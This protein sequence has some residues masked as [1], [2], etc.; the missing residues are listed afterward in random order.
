MFLIFFTF[1]FTSPVNTQTAWVYLIKYQLKKKKNRKCEG[2]CETKRVL[3][4]DLPLN[5]KLVRD[6]K[7][8]IK[9]RFHSE[10]DRNAAYF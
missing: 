9:L 5:K 6:G 3:K 7:W 2:S 10:A 4:W 1:Y 8:N